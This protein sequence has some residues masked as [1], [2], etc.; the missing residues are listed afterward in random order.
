M[1]HIKASGPTSMYAVEAD[2]QNM[3]ERKLHYVES[4]PNVHLSSK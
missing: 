4:C 3:G 2:V 1:L